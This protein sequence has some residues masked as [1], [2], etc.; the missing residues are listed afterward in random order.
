MAGRG[1][2]RDVLC[3]ERRRHSTGSGGEPRLVARITFLNK[4]PN[5]GGDEHGPMAGDLLR[6]RHCTLASVVHVGVQGVPERAD[7]QRLRGVLH[8]GRVAGTVMSPTGAARAACGTSE[9]HRCRACV[10]GTYRGEATGL[11]HFKVLGVPRL[12]LRLRRVSTLRLGL[13][14]G[15]T[16]STLRNTTGI[17]TQHER[18][19]NHDPHGL[20]EPRIETRGPDAGVTCIR[21]RPPLCARLDVLVQDLEVGDAQGNGGGVAGYHWS[22]RGW[23]CLYWVEA[24]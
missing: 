6:R 24:V 20:L 5:R 21:A 19:P 10:R 16:S 23:W 12:G 9:P 3:P 7:V 18:P 15:L 8:Q 17:H 2:R 1:R 4:L 14:R 11:V 22:R 13:G